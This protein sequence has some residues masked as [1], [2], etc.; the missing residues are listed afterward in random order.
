MAVANRVL[1]TLLALALIVAGVVVAAEILAVAFDRGPWLVPYDRWERAA[2][3]TPW[4]DGDVRLASAAM[5][6]AGAGVLAVQ[7]VPRRPS[8]LELVAH[9][10]GAGARLDR[11][12]AE[13]WLGERAGQVE[14]VVTA[15]AK[16]TK[17]VATVRARTLEGDARAVE[18]R[19]HDAVS[20]QMAGLRLERAPRLKV[21]VRTRADHGHRS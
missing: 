12:G 17:K 9:S 6:V 8:A 2:R 20:E 18:R 11:H 1:C 21:E 5:V 4:S 3:A 10:G 15:E 16:I 13:R 14:G 19:V 7:L